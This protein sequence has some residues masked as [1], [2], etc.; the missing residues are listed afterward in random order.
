MNSTITICDSVAPY[1]NKTAEIFQHCVKG[2]DISNNDV[3]IVLII[4]GTILLLTIISVIAYLVQKCNDRKAL[5]NASI[6]KREYE[7]KDR[8]YKHYVELLN[9]LL[10]TEEMLIKKE[11]ASK[12]EEKACRRYIKELKNLITK[13]TLSEDDEEA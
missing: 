10:N 3:T 2:V 13:K 5:E 6:R 12:I 8:E 4:C 9:K 7:E 1:M 11:S